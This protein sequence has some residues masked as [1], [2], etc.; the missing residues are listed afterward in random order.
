MTIE[1]AYISFE[2]AKLLMD[3]GFD[4]GCRY[5]YVNNGNLMFTEEY[6]HN[7]EIKYGT[8]PSCVCTAP[9]Q[10]MAMAWLRKKHNLS[11]EV[12]RTAC[13]Y[14]GCI[15]NIP[16]GTDLKFLEEEGDDLA[17]GQYTTWEGACEATIQYCLE[18]LI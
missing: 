1:E 8:Y 13:G 17:S 14:V 9:T 2:S 6:L 3:K 15:V 12:Y 11:V 7:S 10:Q 18:N 4:E 16:S 5:Y